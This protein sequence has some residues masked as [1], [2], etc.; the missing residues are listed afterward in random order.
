M[1]PGAARVGKGLAWG[2]RLL[3]GFAGYCLMV[4]LQVELVRLLLLLVV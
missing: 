3:L 4:L 2:L 1:L